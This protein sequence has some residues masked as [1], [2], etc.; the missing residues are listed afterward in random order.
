M[1]SSRRIDPAVAPLLAA[2]SNVAPLLTAVF[3]SAH[4]LSRQLT[5]SRCLFVAS[6]DRGL[7]QCD[8]RW[9]LAMLHQTSEYCRRIKR[10][11]VEIDEWDQV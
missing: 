2:P 1:C 7:C 10:A 5:M 3:T 9:Q 11:T 8:L 4:R 6:F